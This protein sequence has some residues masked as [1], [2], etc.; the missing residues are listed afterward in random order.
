MNEC[1]P[2]HARRLLEL[3]ERLDYTFVHRRF[4]EE[5][6]THSSFQGDG[7]GRRHCNER[8]EFLGDRVLGLVVAEL[9]YRKFPG[10]EVGALARRHAALVR[11]D[12]LVEVA[13]ELA[14][15]DCLRLSRG[16]E[17]AGGRH[18]PGLIADACEALIAAIYLDGGFG[19]AKSVVERLW[20]P[21]VERDTAPPKD[22][23]TLLQEWAQAKG[24]ALPHY[25]EASRSGPPH[26]PLF[27]VEVRVDGVEP[28]SATGSSKRAAERAAAEALLLKVSLRND[29]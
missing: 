6:M 25:R 2:A 7:S 9:L 19:A 27:C 12:A 20:L 22:A 1:R 24:R 11:R 16:E 5:A 29:E 15:A 17:E 28:V 18:N 14:F 3:Q 4:L 26:A 21:L 13:G 8:M 10:E 23:K